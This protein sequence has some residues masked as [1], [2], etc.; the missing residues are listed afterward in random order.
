MDIVMPESI[1]TVIIDENIAGPDAPNM[2]AAPFV[3]T[4]RNNLGE[5][6]RPSTVI[7]VEKLLTNM[8]MKNVKAE[9]RVDVATYSGFL[10]TL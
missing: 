2:F 7:N 8:K 5:E 3:V 4:S 10:K 6:P 9:I 1:E